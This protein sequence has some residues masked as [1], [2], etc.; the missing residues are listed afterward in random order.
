[1][2]LAKLVLSHAQ[3]D[4]EFAVRLAR[5][6]VNAGATVSLCVTSNPCASLHAS[7]VRDLISGAEY[8]LIVLTQEILTA[9]GAKGRAQATL[10]PEAAPRGVEMLL[11][12]RTPCRLPAG[13]S[14]CRCTDFVDE[15]R[16]DDAFGC[17]LS[18]LR[19]CR[20]EHAGVRADGQNVAYPRGITIDP[21]PG[22][23]GDLLSLFCRYY[24]HYYRW[25]GAPMSESDVDRLAAAGLIAFREYYDHGQW[26]YEFT[27]DGCRLVDRVYGQRICPCARGFVREPPA[28][29]NCREG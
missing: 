13:L 29:M 2:Y 23:P 26:G 15:R 25:D 6:L 11:I 1:M 10:T 18:C 7:D 19:G 5:D 27:A 14:R 3:A 24:E 12:L 9:V 20:E 4:R 22:L 28:A 16:Y 17:L 8:W 21:I